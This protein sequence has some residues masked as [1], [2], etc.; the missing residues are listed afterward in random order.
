M[1][2]D[3]VP[4]NS[5]GGGVVAHCPLLLAEQ[6]LGGAFIPKPRQ[7]HGDGNVQSFTF[8]LNPAITQRGSGRT[9]S[10]LKCLV[11]TD[12]PLGSAKEV[13]PAL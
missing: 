8:L 12:R 13:F 3:S 10:V 9:N 1:V 2:P 7:K 4:G 6:R 5:E 11:H